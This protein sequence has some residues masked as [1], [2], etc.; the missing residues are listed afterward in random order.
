MAV[1]ALAGCKRQEH[2]A[3]G[4][5][6]ANVPTATDARPPTAL[7]VWLPLLLPALWLAR[8]ARRRLVS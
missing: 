1:F 6:K 2:A 8:R 3:M 7:L 4:A 5:A